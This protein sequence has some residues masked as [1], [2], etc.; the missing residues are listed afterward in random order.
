MRKPIAFILTGIAF[1]MHGMSAQ[2]DF[3]KSIQSVLEA[4]CV[5][6]HG[7][8]KQKGDLRLAVSYTHL[9]LP[10]IRMV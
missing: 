5:D 2:A 1:A 4:R 8:K 6:C 7:S 9:T 10:T 3:T